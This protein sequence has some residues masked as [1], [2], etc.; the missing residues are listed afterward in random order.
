MLL[1]L[2]ESSWSNLFPPEKP[3][4]LCLGLG[5]P[6]SSRIARAQLAFLMETCRLLKVVCIQFRH[7]GSTF[8]F[9]LFSI[10]F[11]FV[12]Q[13]IFLQLFSESLR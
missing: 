12:G 4:V 7:R 11:F 2:L 6:S 1:D 9:F 13:K 5:S 10:F 3:A 8:S